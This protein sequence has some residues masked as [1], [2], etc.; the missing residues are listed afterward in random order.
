MEIFETARKLYP[1]SKKKETIKK[2]DVEGDLIK[3]YIDE[4]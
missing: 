2:V 3:I 4:I 1:S